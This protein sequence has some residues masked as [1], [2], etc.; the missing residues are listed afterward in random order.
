LDLLRHS[1]AGI[2]IIVPS[3]FSDLSKE[4][5]D[6][7]QELEQTMLEESTSVPVYFTV[8]SEDILNVFETVK[9][10]GDSLGPKSSALQSKPLKTFV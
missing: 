6:Q 10:S 3:D 8:E 2:L 9:Q 7:I 5:R 4:L 1:V